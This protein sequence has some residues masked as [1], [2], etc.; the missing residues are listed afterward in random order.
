M[1][2]SFV[3]D[4]VLDP[5]P[6]SSPRRP[7]SSSSPWELGTAIDDALAVKRKT[8][9]FTTTDEKI[10]RRKGA[11]AASSGAGVEGGEDEDDG[12][13]FEHHHPHGRLDSPSDSPSDSF[14]DLNLSRVLCRAC[15]TLGFSTPTPI[16]S[17]C[18]PLVLSG[19]DLVASAITGSGKTAAYGLPLLERLLHRPAHVKATYVLVL[20][21]TRE[22]AV[23]THSMLEKLATFAKNPSPVRLSLVI[24]GLSM[25]TQAQALRTKPE[26]V[27]AT[28]NRLIDHLTNTRSVDLDDMS[29]LVLDEADR[30][31]ELG[32][33]E[34]VREVISHCPGRRQTLLFSA[35][36][37]QSV[38][39][40]VALSLRNPV[41]VAVDPKHATPQL[42]QQ[43]AVLL[44]GALAGKKEAILMSL[45]T[46]LFKEK[47][48]VFAR[49]KQCAHR[50]K[51]IFGLAGLQASELHGNMS[52]AQRLR[53]LE[54]FRAGA[55][56]FLLATDVASRGLDILGVENVI[57]FDEPDVVTTYVHRI[58][59]TARA[60]R[61]GR[62]VTFLDPSNR[63]L[64]KQIVKHSG[65]KLKQRIVA[66]ETIDKWTEAIAAMAEDIAKIM[67]EEKQE[68]ILQKA[69]MEALRAE[70]LVEHHNEIMAR[71]AKTWFQS[72]K[73]KKQTQDAAR[74][75]YEDRRKGISSNNKRK[76]QEERD[77]KKK[78]EQAKQF[79]S[80]SM[81]RASKSQEKKLRNQGLEPN[82]AMNTII[83][84]NESVS[85]KRKSQS[86]QQQQ[87]K[88]DAD[89][90]EGFKPRASKVQKTEANR[91][92]RGGKAAKAF[93]SKKKY[94][95]R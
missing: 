95:R 23:Q 29:T 83:A 40:L 68:R 49:T 7:S 25:Q 37:T 39:E 72:K 45:C 19:R 18:V 66:D 24:G 20:V 57:S 16:Q 2:P 11:R 91:R 73:D 31:L 42:L 47:T 82:R 84:R 41:R 14:A 81:A 28:P 69:E 35:T 9:T 21:P 15:T 48:V 75:E 10:R 53:A 71:P 44:K 26:V 74:E 1:D 80:T 55:A 58:G 86:Q 5:G 54:D 50:L 30:L 27:V 46:R 60:G 56:K 52:Q 67:L 38:Q 94:K 59:R 63:A 92:K 36:M 85:R 62:A 22:L 51:L 78:A 90:D 93:K 89:E 13:F 12:G 34:Q 6:A 61:G 32:F 88:K 17:A 33:Q 76:K 79:L 70:N 8:R 87:K 77:K 64:I 65:K 4:S 43:E 3:F